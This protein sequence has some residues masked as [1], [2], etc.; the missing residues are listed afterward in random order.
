MF[1]GVTE[2]G[3]HCIEDGVDKRSFASGVPGRGGH[4]GGRR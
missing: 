3:R 1:S 4:G 2:R